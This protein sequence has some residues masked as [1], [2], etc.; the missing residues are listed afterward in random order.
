MRRD[1]MTARFKRDNVA[2]LAVVLFFLIL[3]TEIFLA[4]WIPMR[5]YKDSVFAES[6]V[7]IGTMSKFDG[8]RKD[9]A[10][11]IKD[12]TDPAVVTEM[13][14][15]Q[16]Q[17]NML[18]IYLKSDDR[19]KRLSAEQVELVRTELENASRQYYRLKR[20][21]SV[22]SPL[23]PDITPCIKAIAEGKI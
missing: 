2:A 9:L 10:Q 12:Q 7:R 11:S 15:L 22:S 20:G 3:A 13:K 16:A 23:K 6:V 18:A 21:K 14:M 5:L 8:L 17:L 4:V 19:S 1:M